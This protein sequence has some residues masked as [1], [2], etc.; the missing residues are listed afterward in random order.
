MFNPITRDFLQYSTSLPTS[1]NSTTTLPYWN[2]IRNNSI[3]FNEH[4]GN[5]MAYFDIEKSALVE[6]Q[7]P[8]T[9]QLWGNTSNPLKFDI[10]SKGSAWFT[11]WTENK[12]GML[13]SSKLEKLPFWLSVSKDD[14]ELD[15]KSLKGDRLEIIVRP[16]E[17]IWTSQ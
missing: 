16:M 2:I 15:T 8:T 9:P 10:D 12:I 13:D 7:I 17:L 14:A 11:E 5:A 6:Y 1:R 3:W 4:E